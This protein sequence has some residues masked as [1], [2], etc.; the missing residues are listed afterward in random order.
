MD[1]IIREL[2]E[3]GI[4]DVGRIDGHFVVDSQLML[5][6]ENNQIRTTVID[7]PP[8]EKRYAQEAVDYRKY[9][10]D[11]TK[12]IFLAHVDGEIAGRIILRQ[13]WNKYAYIEDIVVDEKFRRRGIGRALID[14][15]RQ[16]ARQMDL[17]GIMLET[18]NNNVRACR[19]YE[20]CG[21]KIGGFDNSVY[22]GLD[23][24]TDEVAIFY[25]LHFEA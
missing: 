5:H 2:D 6:A 7:L 1:M 16:W 21:F 10:A 9:L 14:Q 4:N 8:G 3:S 25:Y 24:D 23:A 13:N 11:P 20:S 12:A 19:F 15:A 22:R 17:P 18:Q